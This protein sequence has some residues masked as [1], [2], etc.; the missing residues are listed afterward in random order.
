MNI[1]AI[2]LARGGSKGVVKKNIRSLAGQPL[3]V[4]TIREAQKS[5]LIDEYV[6]ST[7]SDEIAAVVEG[8]GA[9]VPFRRPPELASD[10]ASSADALQH[11]VIEMEELRGIRYD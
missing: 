3:I 7:D 5:R 8:A 6:V 10:T 11:A 2:T 1:L 4:H 9:I